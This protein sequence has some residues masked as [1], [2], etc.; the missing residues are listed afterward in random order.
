MIFN[1]N[2]YQTCH[3]VSTYDLKKYF[4]AILEY[5]AVKCD[6][7]EKYFDERDEAFCA[8]GAERCGTSIRQ[9]KV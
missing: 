4:N 6:E 8:A 1:H 3:F 5:A 9:E 7:E 2:K